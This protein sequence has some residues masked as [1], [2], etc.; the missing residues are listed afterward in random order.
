MFNIKR[1][2]ELDMLDDFNRSI[3]G[4]VYALKEL[5]ET[6]A[7]SVLR[8]KLTNLTIALITRVAEVIQRHKAEDAK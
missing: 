7:N 8:A 6:E 4:Y 5:P 3:L 1:K 2:M